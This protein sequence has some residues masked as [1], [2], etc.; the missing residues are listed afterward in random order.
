MQNKV[1]AM[2]A[3][4]C[5]IAGCMDLGVPYPEG[6]LHTVTIRAVYPAGF[7]A[8]AGAQVSV[9]NILTGAAYKVT[10]GEG[11][12]A[13]THLG[14][15]V[16][17]VTVTDRSD[18]DLFNGSERIVVNGADVTLNLPLRHS[19]PGKIVI[20]ELYCGGCPKDPQEGT[21][22]SDQ[23]VMVHNNTAQTQYL[24]SL[25]VGTLSPYNSTANN[26]W[27]DADG[28]LPDFLPIIQ[29]IFMING[30]GTQ[31]PLA[32]GQDAV[33]CLRGA[34]DHTVQYPLSVNLNRPDYFVCYNTVLFPNPV[35]HPA[36]GDK[37]RED[38]IL[39]VV[40]KT[41]QA[42]AFTVSVSSPAFVIFRAKGQDIMKFVANPDNV[43]PIPGGSREPVVAIPPRWA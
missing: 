16:Y 9:D 30:N 13:R 23:Y 10:A 34:I 7:T 18:S 4:C 35:Y 3:A 36:P 42:N 27:E 5:L 41:G 25:C 14:N 22:Q 20:K 29:A 39:E 8:G 17:T 1:I 24:D 21:Y 2:L 40:I 12:V 19:E 28:N 31:F 38:H 15:G 33:I 26:V 6:S 43:I 11:A 37:I 32:P